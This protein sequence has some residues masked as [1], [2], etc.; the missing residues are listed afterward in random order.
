M[1]VEIFL[2]QRAA[3]EILVI[4]DMFVVFYVNVR[5]EDVRALFAD[6]L[7]KFGHDLF[8]SFT[9]VEHHSFIR[10]S[11]YIIVLLW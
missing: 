9:L 5:N 4:S 3:Y 6:Q 1:K 11:V 10:T 8:Y 7:I 2:R